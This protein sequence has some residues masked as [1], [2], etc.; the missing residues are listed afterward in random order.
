MVTGLAQGVSYSYDERHQILTV[1]R[2]G[3]KLEEQ[4]RLDTLDQRRGRAVELIRQ[5]HAAE[6]FT[7]RRFRPPVGACA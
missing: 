5:L 1:Y 6:Q 2:C 3:V 7:S 4:G